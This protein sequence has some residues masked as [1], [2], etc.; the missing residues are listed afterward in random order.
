MMGRQHA[1]IGAMTGLAVATWLKLAAGFA[2]VLAV[3]TL[4]LVGQLPHAGVVVAAE[5]LAALLGGGVSAIAALVP[6]LDSDSSTLGSLVPKLAHRFLLLS[7][8]QGSHSLLGNWTAELSTYWT[9]NVVILSGA[10]SQPAAAASVATTAA[11][12]AF[13]VSMLVRFGYLSHLIAD[14]ITEEGCRWFYL[15]GSIAQFLPRP[16]RRLTEWHGGIPLFETASWPEYAVTYA[17]VGLVL[18]LVLDLQ[19]FAPVLMPGVVSAWTGH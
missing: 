16:L 7:H 12:V 10:V 17:Y 19:R 14:G 8:R 1:T 9:W 11:T 15:P 5:G 18:F 2:A 3:L 6:D 13:Q 4:P